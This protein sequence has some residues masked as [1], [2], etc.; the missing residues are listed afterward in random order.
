MLGVPSG[1]QCLQTSLPL[2]IQHTLTGC[3]LGTRPQA[4]RQSKKHTAPAHTLRPGVMD[5]ETKRSGLQWRT[6][7][8]GTMGAKRA[9]GTAWDI[10]ESSG[11]R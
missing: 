11:R 8:H 3:L 10:R 5:T 7:T 4:G 2:F 1:F 9:P 6:D